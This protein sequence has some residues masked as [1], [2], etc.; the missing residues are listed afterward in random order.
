M[1]FPPG[2]AHVSNTVSFSATGLLIS[3]E[4]SSSRCQGLLKNIELFGC[5]NVWVTIE[6][7]TNMEKYYPETFDKILV[8]APCSGEGM[9]RKEPDLIKSWIEKDDT[10]YPPIQ[11][12]ILNAAVS[13]LKPG[14]SIVYS[15][16]TFPYLLNLQWLP[17]HCHNQIIQCSLE[18]P[19]ILKN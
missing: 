19:Y 3:N 16:C 8:D 5:D 17:R 11:K 18:A 4:I 1:L 12:N 6:D 2:A 14:G 15:T 9:F 13:M 7:L 10:F